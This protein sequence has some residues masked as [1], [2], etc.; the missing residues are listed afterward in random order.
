MKQNLW[1]YE[2]VIGYSGYNSA[3]FITPNSVPVRFKTD[4]S[5]I[6]PH[7][8]TV[9]FWSK[10]FQVLHCT[11]RYRIYS[12]VSFIPYPCFVLLCRVRK[13]LIKKYFLHIFYK[14]ITCIVC[15]RGS[16][17]LQIDVASIIFFVV[18]DNKLFP[19]RCTQK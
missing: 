5:I 13:I 11:L 3:K 10:T 8:E 14:N 6:W 4:Y 7:H 18:S 1:N 15:F 2:R 9:N 19:S 12:H 17:Y 16:K